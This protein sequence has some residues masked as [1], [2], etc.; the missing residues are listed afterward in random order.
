[1]RKPVQIAFDKDGDLT[2]LADDGSVWSRGTRGGWYRHPFLPQPGSV[3]DQFYDAPAVRV[4]GGDSITEALNRAILL[5]GEKNR[6]VSVAHNEVRILVRPGNRVH[7]L[8]DLWQ[9]PKDSTEV[10]ALQEDGP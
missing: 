5:A 6:A 8:Y 1:M 3:E 9:N 10:L 7:D 2:V 4:I